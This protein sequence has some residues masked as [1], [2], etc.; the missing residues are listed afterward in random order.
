MTSILIEVPAKLNAAARENSGNMREPVV[1][2][3]EDDRCGEY[4][5]AA[6]LVLL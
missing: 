1:K 3:E 5:E 2:K 6:V 4:A